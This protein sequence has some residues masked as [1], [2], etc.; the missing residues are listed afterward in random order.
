MTGCRVV[1]SRKRNIERWEK[2]EERE[3]KILMLVE[4]EEDEKEEK[5]DGEKNTDA[6]K[7]GGR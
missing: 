2:E 6:G 4:E 5:E 1:R 7:E 3:R